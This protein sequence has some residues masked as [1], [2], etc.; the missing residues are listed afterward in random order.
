M[1]VPTSAEVYEHVSVAVVSLPMTALSTR[2][3]CSGLA[4]PL[5]WSANDV[6]V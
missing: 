6:N 3:I 5:P 1:A 4:P 2:K